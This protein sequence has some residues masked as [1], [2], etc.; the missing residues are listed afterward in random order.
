[1]VSGRAGGKHLCGRASAGAGQGV[2]YGTIYDCATCIV[3]P[4]LLA[5]IRRNVP[6]IQSMIAKSCRNS[7]EPL[8]VVRYSEV[9]ATQVTGA[10]KPLWAASLGAGHKKGAP[11][12]AP[13]VM[14]LYAR[15][16]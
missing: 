14:H 4:R 9:A 16:T 15:R 2:G 3:F 7:C 6:P 5:T 8:A 13:K 1:M 10:E 11:R 12:R